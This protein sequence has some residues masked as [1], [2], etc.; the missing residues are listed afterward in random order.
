MNKFL[1]EISNTLRRKHYSLRTEKSYVSW[2]KRFILFHQK[3]HP[4]DMR[5][6]EIRAFLNHL[7]VN[8]NVSASTQNQALNA[9]VFLYKNVLGI[10]LGDFGIIEKA[11]TLKILPTV[12]SRSETNKILS[13]ME[14]K[15][16]LIAKMLYGC[17]FRLLEC[18]RLRVKDIDF[19]R[20]EITIHQAK[21]GK[22][23][24][25][26]LPKLLKENLKEQ[27]IR[28]KIIYEQE[29]L[30]GFGEVSLPYALDR[31][32]KNAGKEWKWQYVFPAKKN[33]K[34]PRS[35]KMMRHHIFENV[36]QRAVKKAAAIAGIEKK[37][38]PHT[39]RH[40]FATHLLESGYDIR[41]V[42]E[43]L[44][45]QDVSTTMIYTHILNKGGKGV[46]S[47]LDTLLPN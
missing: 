44:G 10:D 42:Q 9:I 39:F 29:L 18:L 7:A 28:T 14:G 41:T 46:K 1:E 34:D 45:H 20:N 15:T 35:G 2:A 40:S 25:T 8:R 27:I 33:S 13:V 16:G 22:D 31:K 32:Y 24:K 19:E 5:E 21:G 47:P 11:K 36:V 26:M 17:G 4:K 30:K 3:Q 12:L 23:R 43:L 6:K 38:S 37:V